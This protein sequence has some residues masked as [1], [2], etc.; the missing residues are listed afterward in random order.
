MPARRTST[1]TARTDGARHASSAMSK[2]CAPCARGPGS[3]SRTLIHGVRNRCPAIGRSPSAF[4]GYRSLSSRGK[5]PVCGHATLR[6]RCVGAPGVE[7]GSRRVKA[8]SLPIELRS[9]LLERAL[10]FGPDHRRISFV[11]DGRVER[12]HGVRNGATTRRSC[13]AANRHACARNEKG[14]PR[15]PWG[16]L[17]NGISVFSA[18]LPT[19]RVHAL[20][21]LEG[22]SRIHRIAPDA[23][24]AMRPAGGFR[25]GD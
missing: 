15:F 3:E 16:G 9:L 23:G 22:R 1:E 4:G 24:R 8:G 2:S 13:P 21:R 7:P 12:L 11:H 14:H 25:D 10:S 5:S 17:K 19:L 6:T 20:G 18:A